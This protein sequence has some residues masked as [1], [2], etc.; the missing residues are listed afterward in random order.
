MHWLWCFLD[1]SIFISYDREY[2]IKEGG[3]G[4]LKDSGDS[5]L[6]AYYWS[7]LRNSA[8]NYA[9]WYALGDCLSQVYTV[10]NKYFRITHS[11]HER[12]NGVR[13]EHF[14]YI[15]LNVLGLKGWYRLDIGHT[16]GNGR[17]ETKVRKVN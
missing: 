8:V 3:K 16:T 11:I 2:N 12:G 1:D 6:K 13:L 9:N 4:S 10:N 15:P 7:V 14:F 5:L 17:I